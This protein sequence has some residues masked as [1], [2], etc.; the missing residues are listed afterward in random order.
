MY[1]NDVNR[2][3]YSSKY[4]LKC[5]KIYVHEE[6]VLG[7]SLTSFSSIASVLCAYSS[8]NCSSKK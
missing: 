5:S 2:K 3:Q 6:D 4:K 8:G 1:S 7:L